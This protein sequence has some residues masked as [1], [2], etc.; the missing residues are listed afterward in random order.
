MGDGV[1]RSIYPETVTVPRNSMALVRSDLVH[2][3][4][5][6]ADVADRYGKAPAEL[7]Y[8]GSTRFHMYLQHK[9][10]KLEDAILLVDRKVF[11]NSALILL[12][13]DELDI[14]SDNDGRNYEVALAGGGP[15]A[16]NKN[17]TSVTSGR[18]RKV[19]HGR[20]TC[21]SSSSRNKGSGGEPSKNSSGHGLSRSRSSSSSSGRSSDGVGVASFR[22]G[23]DRGPG[24]STALRRAPLSQV[25]RGRPRSRSVGGDDRISERSRSRGGT[26]SR[27]VRKRRRSSRSDSLRPASSDGAR[28]RRQS[29]ARRI[30]GR[31]DRRHALP[32]DGSRRRGRTKSPRRLR[33]RSRPSPSPSGRLGAGSGRAPRR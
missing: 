1:R 22:G 12:D 13:E 11:I 17:P 21:D 28:S 30:A 7:K 31:D 15:K 5:S 29:Q 23:E 9:K 18:G 3:G 24:A 26:T 27:R 2:A 14:L 25:R 10:D 4:A 19:G 33:S 32:S 8:S 6:A 20:S 16:G